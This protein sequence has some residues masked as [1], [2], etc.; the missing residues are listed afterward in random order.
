MKKLLKSGIYLFIALLLLNLYSCDEPVTDEEVY[1]TF[2][3]EENK[4]YIEDAGI[5]LLDEVKSMESDPAF[6]YNANFVNYLN[7]SEGIV[8]NGETWKSEEI[9]KS[10]GLG[11]YKDLAQFEEIGSN[12]LM[13]TM[14]AYDDEP[15]TL[16]ELYDYFVGVYTWNFDTYS[17]DYE[18][19]GEVIVFNFPSTETGTVNDA[20][21]TLLYEGIDIPGN[22]WEDE[23][24]YYGD[25]PTFISAVLEVA[26]TEIS[27]ISIEFGYESDGMPNSFVYNTSMGEYSFIVS[28]ENQGNLNANAEFLFKNTTTNLLRFAVDGAGDWSDENIEANTHYILWYYNEETW[29]YVEEE[30]TK[31]EYDNFV[32]EDWNSGT[33]TEVDAHKVVEE[34]NVVFEAEGVKV[35]AYV[36]IVSLVDKVN[37]IEAMYNYETQEEVIMTAIVA[38]INENASMS[39]KDENGNLIAVGEAYLITDEYYYEWED[40]TYVEYYPGLRFIFADGSKID[41]ETYFN[42]G[43]DDLFNALETYLEELD[44]TYD[45]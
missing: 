15:Q 27:S 26:E 29:E 35:S 19:V 25:L 36:N 30:I 24:E 12:K 41:A 28:A 9:Q 32:R 23:L 44:N 43:F 11:I 3:I 33:Y 6:D 2:S 38:A 18:Q 10:F 7:Q 45:L 37:E 17:W 42:E 34:G 13:K 21:Y 16:Q 39:I 4:Q 8:N 14:M 40:Y 20:T 1:N 31:E 5:S 22:M